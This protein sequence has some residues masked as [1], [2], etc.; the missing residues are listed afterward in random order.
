MKFKKFFI[1][2]GLMVTFALGIFIIRFV[3]ND[4]TTVSA[5]HV[6]TNEISNDL[7]FTGS[8]DGIND[9]EKIVKM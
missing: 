6:L 8:D 1:V 2:L 5:D 7:L 9:R 3:V 4:M